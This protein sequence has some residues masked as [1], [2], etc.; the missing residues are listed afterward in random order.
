MKKEIFSCKRCGHCCHGETTVSLN[1][2]DLAR[3][4]EY[5]GRPAGEVVEKYLRVRGNVVQMKIVD[6]HCIFYRE[7]CLVHPARPWRCAQWPL[8]PSIMGDESNLSAIRDS[9]PGIDKTLAY[10]D[11]CRKLADR[12]DA[13]K[14]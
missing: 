13:E 4:V 14:K 3:M 6:G 5:F 9:C 12:L 11:F 7:G 10:D 1:E 2:D 8:H